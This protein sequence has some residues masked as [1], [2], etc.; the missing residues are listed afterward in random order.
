MEPA[1][2]SK[3]K[4][5]LEDFP[6]LGEGGFGFGAADS[7]D[8]ESSRADVSTT[9]SARTPPEPVALAPRPPK[10][11]ATTSGG[12]RR[13]QQV[14]GQ[15]AGFQPVVDLGIDEVT[16]MAAEEVARI[17][18]RLSELSTS[19]RR[20]DT[21]WDRDQIVKQAMQDYEVA[22][23]WVQ[24]IVLPEEDEW[25]PSDGNH[26]CETLENSPSASVAASP[27]ATPPSGAG[28][29][30]CRSPV[31]GGDA[32]GASI[33]AMVQAP[34]ATPVPPTLA[35]HPPPPLL[36]PMTMQCGTMDAGR[37]ELPPPPPS[38]PPRFLPDHFGSHSPQLAL[39]SAS[40]R[41]ENQWPSHRRVNSCDFAQSTQPSS[42]MQTGHVAAQQNAQVATAMFGMQDA[43]GAQGTLPQ[44]QFH[45]QVLQTLPPHAQQQQ[46]HSA[47]VMQGC[48]HG[49]HQ[50]PNMQQQSALQM[51]QQHPQQHYGAQGMGQVQHQQCGQPQVQFM[52]GLQPRGFQQHPQ[53]AQSA[54]SQ[55]AFGEAMSCGFQLVAFPA[56][57]APLDGSSPS[58]GQTLATAAPSDQF[59]T[60]SQTQTPMQHNSQ[61]V[62]PQQCR[63]PCHRFDPQTGE[64]LHADASKA[65][66]RLRIMN[67]ETGKEV[68]PGVFDAECNSGATEAKAADSNFF[69]QDTTTGSMN[70]SWEW[71][72]SCQETKDRLYYIRQMEEAS[73]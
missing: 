29:G 57:G 48:A 42:A 6:V 44:Q 15:D 30:A 50:M 24:T 65:S 58:D 61:W 17:A 35:T 1:P 64:E 73:A 20:C 2:C 43:L 46:Q 26:E 67:P 5:K 59:R 19:M 69:S 22:M 60:T 28:P 13:Q 41:A 14:A 55:G 37:E 3:S 70:A 54:T 49:R 32:I 31:A 52:Q 53:G 51:Q 63:N 12:K 8:A 62:V 45:Q 7:S 4:M 21:A 66:R 16:Q 39:A 33:L 10:S 27:T 25:S 38:S 40:R 56:G 34:K 23:Q 36:P 71:P 18:G 72:M 9:D 47:P 11:V 68:L